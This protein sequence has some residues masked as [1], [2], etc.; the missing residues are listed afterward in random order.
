M[1]T[2]LELTQE[3]RR[4]AGVS[5]TGPTTVTGQTGMYDKLVRWTSRA[6]TEI[7]NKQVRW[8]FLRATLTKTLVIG[9]RTYALLS[10]WGTNTVNQFDPDGAF[11]YKTSTDDQ[12]PLKW[13]LFP[14]FRR[15]WNHG[16]G[17][18]RP[19]NI[20]LAPGYVASFELIPDYAYTVLLD[21][22]QTP[23]E[24]TNDADLP[25]CPEHFHRII[26]WRALMKYAGAEG[27]RDLYAH[28]R[29]EYRD[30]YL[31]LCSDQ[32]D[33]PGTNAAHPIALGR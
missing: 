10:A 32:L 4:E 23:E 28:A 25:A 14:D 30:M 8:Y 15:R 16:Y 5:G 33:L 11:I 1:P 24:L 7:Q 31:D 3:L 12:G 22:W 26:M 13:H 21:Y 18:G 6:W 17:T 27:D 19:G 2:F 9:T 20:T 29:S